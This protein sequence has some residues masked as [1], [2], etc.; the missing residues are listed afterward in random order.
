M[1]YFKRNKGAVNACEVSDI[2]DKFY[3]NST[4]SVNILIKH[5]QSY[6]AIDLFSFAKEYEKL[7]ECQMSCVPFLA[8]HVHIC[9][10][11]NL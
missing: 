11:N 4:E 1:G 6:K 9:Y 2:E 3:N 10:Q 8:Y 7:I 5:W